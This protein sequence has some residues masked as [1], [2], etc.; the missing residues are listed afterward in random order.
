MIS[1]TATPRYSA[2]SLTVEPELTRISSVASIAVLSIGAT[3]SSYVRRRL[4][5]RRGRRCG[6]LAGPPCWRREAWESITTRRRPPGPMSPGVRSPVRES[7]V[8]RTRSAAAAA[9]AAAGAG[10]PATGADA[11]GGAGRR[12]GLL[13]RWAVADGRAVGAGRRCRAVAAQGLQRRGLLDRGGGGLGLYA[14]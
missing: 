12:G 13:D 5:P 11:G 9:A 10:A 1:G 6:W 4:R 2:T 3:V 7:R 14:G 8:G